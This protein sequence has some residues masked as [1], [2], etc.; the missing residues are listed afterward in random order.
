MKKITL[1]VTRHGKAAHNLGKE[2]K[3]TFAGSSI[4][5]ELAKEGISNAHFLAEK[6][7]KRGC[8]DLIVR[9]PLLRSKQTAEI[10]Q[11]DILEKLRKKIRIEKLPELVEIDIGDFAGHTEEEVKKIYPEVA[12]NFYD[13]NIKKWNFP[14][15][16]NYKQ[17]SS[18]VDA[19]MRKIISL[20]PP[21]GTVVIAGHGMINRVL[22]Y[23]FDNRNKKLW[24]L[25]DSPISVFDSLFELP[26]PKSLLL[27]GWFFYPKLGGVETVML[28]QA[29]YFQNRGYLVSVLTSLVRGL[30]KNDN[31]EGIKIFRRSFINSEKKSPYSKIDKE[32]NDLLDFIKPD[33]IQFHNGS[34]PAGSSD[35]NAGAQNIKRLY[36]IIRS[37]NITVL[38]YAHN[39]QLKNPE[40]TKQLRRIDWDCLI[41]VSKFVKNSWRKLG[42]KARR[43]EVVYNGVELDKFHRVKPNSTITSLKKR[44]EKII[45]FPA[46]VISIS[47]GTL[48]K[49]KNFSLLL[50][51]GSKLIAGGSDNFRIVALLNQS[52]RSQKDKTAYQN[53]KNTVKKL[54]L[55]DNIT[56]LPETLPE[57]MPSYYAAS[58]IVCVPSYSECFAL[59][60]LEAMA[61]GKIAI[62]S[63]TG[64]SV[65]LIKNGENGFLVDPDNPDKLVRVLKKILNG[66]IDPAKIAK[67]ASRTIQR[68]D[69]KKKMREVEKIYDK[70]LKN[71]A[72]N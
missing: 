62:A 54:N 65:E 4:D 43:T 55:T 16:E 67:Q 35:M 33:I 25:L 10:I 14:N 28:N 17:I 50:Q 30:P 66:N 38:D 21:N 70:L 36:R 52:R 18:R 23:K 47:S 9:S 56:F 71:E 44:G 72:A 26:A 11:N 13:G 41:C 3:H 68:Y 19:A 27:I 34:Y 57:N 40:I 59:V 58:D 2:D 12:K 63:R 42:Y 39:A 6:I 46:R 24:Q 20:T 8:C 32:F 61:S 31:F 22:F 51:A 53:L 64:G 48:S 45:L 60:Y 7:I 29:R 5:N 69:V 1:I 15:G 49:Q 37:K